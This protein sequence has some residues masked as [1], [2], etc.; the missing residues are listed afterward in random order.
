[1]PASKENPSIAY[2]VPTLNEESVLHAT[3]ERIQKQAGPSEIIVADGGSSD[4]TIEIAKRFSC[5]VSQSE[6]GRGLQMNA[7]A[8]LAKSALLCFVHADTLL[9]MS[10]AKTIREYLSSPSVSAGSFRLSFDARSKR[11]DFYSYCSRINH[12]LFTYGDQALYLRRETFEKIGG[13]KTYPFLE[14]IEIQKRLRK[15]GKFVKAENSA[16]T[17]ARRFRVKGPFIQQFLNLAIVSGYLIGI[18]PQSLKRFYTY[19]R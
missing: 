18:S 4:A 3:L 8:S 11:L 12:L 6:P 16:I 17:S 10:A 7:G 15:L 2:I 14:D 5:R 19:I 13:F 9:P 1:M